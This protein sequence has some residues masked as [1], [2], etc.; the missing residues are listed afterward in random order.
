MGSGCAAAKEV[1]D[2]I[3]IG[4]DFDATITAIKWGRNIYH[5]IGR[6]L[7]F[8]LTVNIS[9]VLT[10]IIG[11]P[12]LAESPF[13]AGQ[14]LWIN[15]IMDTFA[16]FALATEPPMDS[17]VAGEPYTEDQPVL[18]PEVWRQ[19]FGVSV[20]NVGLMVF[21]MT[22]GKMLGGFDYNYSTTTLDSNQT[23]GKPQDKLKH[24][25]MMYNTF[26][27]L[28]VFN[29]INCR[30]IGKTDLMV[31]DLHRNFYFCIVVGGTF[32]A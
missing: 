24:M 25:T 17:I 32:G 27:F 28:Q 8:Q 1:S 6:F 4:D 14:L 13:S 20:W 2:V 15:L 30:K 29:E 16:A 3:L 9:V 5:N 21:L 12:I 7:Q 10:I 18:T 31:F 11:T 19:V 22:F 26:I 23:D